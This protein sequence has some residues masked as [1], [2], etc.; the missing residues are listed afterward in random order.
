MS[1]PD[2]SLDS[3]QCSTALY[4][5]ITHLSSFYVTSPADT[6]IGFRLLYIS[7]HN[8][9]FI[10]PLKRK[11]FRH[12]LTQDNK[13]EWFLF[14][15]FYFQSVVGLFIFCSLYSMSVNLSVKCILLFLLML[16]IYHYFEIHFENL[17]IIF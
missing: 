6:R 14:L 12:N 15:L 7:L 2:N 1:L 13:L 16:L 5:P 8:W 17:I 11:D 3:S 4:K 9:D 10:N